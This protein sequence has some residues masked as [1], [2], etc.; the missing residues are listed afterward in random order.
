MKALLLCH[1]E[2]AAMAH[3]PAEAQAQM[4]KAMMD[5]NQQLIQAGVLTAAGQLDSPVNAQRVSLNSGKLQTVHGPALA[6]DIQIG[7]YY[8]LDVPTLADA[9]AWAN[10]CPVAQ[11]G[12]GV[13]VREVSYSPM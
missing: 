3:V 5:F 8:V 9:T 2:P 4:M 13:E 10:R 11:M 6:G 12:G 7:G 1:F